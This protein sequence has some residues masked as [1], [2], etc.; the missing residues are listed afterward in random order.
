MRIELLAECVEVLKNCDIDDPNDQKTI[1]VCENYIMHSYDLYL[2]NCEINGYEPLTQK[3]YMKELMLNEGF[4]KKLLGGAA[5][6]AG[7]VGA[8]KFA[9]GVNANAKANGA[10]TGAKNFFGN[11]KN[12]VNQ[13]GGLAGAAKNTFNTSMRGKVADQQYSGASRNTN[14]T[15]GAQTMTL[16]SKKDA[17]KAVKNN[18]N[19]QG[20]NTVSYDRHGQTQTVDANSKQGKRILA[21][22]EKQAAGQSEEAQQARA[23]AAK[24]QSNTAKAE[25]KRRAGLTDEQRAA[26]D[27]Q[28]QANKQA[29]L[30]QKQQQGQA[31][32][33][34]AR[35]DADAKR[36]EEEAQHRQQYLADLKARKQQAQQQQ[37]QTPAPKT[38]NPQNPNQPT[39][40]VV[41]ETF[42][43]IFNKI[44]DNE[45]GVLNEQSMSLANISVNE[46]LKM[47]VDCPFVS[48]EEFTIVNDYSIP[49]SMFRNTL[50]EFLGFE[51]NP[52][53][54]S[55]PLTPSIRM[56]SKMV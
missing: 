50:R 32:A 21:G 19:L 4:F 23:N 56:P 3:E 37:T 27:A 15:T 11:A 39:Q 42:I 5:L 55:K 33:K 43:N 12:F 7:A 52:S 41:Q 35:E 54:L 2:E 34:Q 51:Y 29:Q 36:K 20:N 18:Q 14:V 49:E 26:E 46:V 40:Q 10:Q 24:A 6:A 48:L 8:A 13:S 28:N 17:K 16:A 9:R 47:A 53:E 38:P 22:Q 1:S 31:D 25:N 45:Q 30:Q 44:F